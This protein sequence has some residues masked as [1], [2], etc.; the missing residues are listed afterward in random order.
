[1]LC[2]R[3]PPHDRRAPPTRPPF[4]SA[5][6]AW[7]RWWLMEVAKL[8]AVRSMRKRL[9]SF[10]LRARRFDEAQHLRLSGV[11]GARHVIPG[12]IVP[13]ILHDCGGTL[14]HWPL[15]CTR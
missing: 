12:G 3:W 10:P 15:N 5:V 13:T 6:S 2:I 9:G 7:R 8:E 14:S 1:M 11:D 4:S